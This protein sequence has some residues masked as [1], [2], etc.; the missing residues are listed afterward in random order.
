MDSP[1]TPSITS[2]RAGQYLR[3]PNGYRAFI[4][5]PLP[6][7]P[8]I[9]ISGDLQGLLSQADR[10]LGRLDGS[11]HT[12]PHPDL[13][14]YMYVRKE[15]VLSSQIEGTQSSLQDVLAAEAGMLA[16]DRPQDVAEVVSYVGAMN[17]GL[18]RLAELPVCVRLIR[19]IHGELLKGVRGSHL[20]PG[21][22]RASQ[23]W[24][25][26]AGCTLN[27]AIFVPPPPHEVPKVLA[28]LERFL[29][30]D[31]SV[32]LLVK[33]GL[34]HAQFE[35]IHPFLDGNGRIGR[36]LITFLLCEQKVL[37]K[38]V[39]YL[40][41]YFKRQRQAY[42]DHLQAVRD[43]GTWEAWLAFFLRGIIEV[44]G[45]ATETAR[46]ILSLR[47]EHRRAITDSLGRAAGNG[48]RVLEH[49]YQHPIVSV[50]EVQQLTGTT[51][52]AA[53]DLVAKLV[54]S[55]IL[56][57]FTGK[58]RNRRFIYQSYVDLFWDRESEAN[59]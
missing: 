4:P 35:T 54:N 3:Q 39:L 45:Q 16:P 48:H 8:P 33:I 46:R 20:T 31:T 7:D 22:L 10:A 5:E 21:D 17:Y 18:A 59:A 56:R 30:T 50:N 26:P 6:P 47:E 2:T 36:L 57:E 23:N 13:F 1:G 38:P 9:Q 37:L 11:I 12:L 28:D 53:N 49:L 41:Y 44:S 58:A 24:I 55:G 42:Y 15:A 52:P 25:E 40:S 32:P 34:A 27:E 14:V 43:A 51:Y 29:H 19:E